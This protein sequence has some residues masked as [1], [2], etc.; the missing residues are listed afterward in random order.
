MSK[1]K[2]SLICPTCQRPERFAAM[3]ATIRNTCDD[4]QTGDLELMVGLDT[5]DPRYH[6]YSVPGFAKLS[7]NPSGADI[8]LS[9]WTNQLVAKSTGEIICLI[10]DDMLIRT[11]G[12]TDQVRAAM[13]ND[14][15]G[16][17][18]PMDLYN[19]KCTFPMF[20]VNMV[21]AQDGICVPVELQRWFLDEWYSMAGQGI[22]RITRLDGVVFEHM[23][24]FAEKSASDA[25]YMKAVD[26]GAPEADR[27]VFYGQDLSDRRFR[28]ITRI[29]RQTHKRDGAASEGVDAFL[30]YDPDVFNEAF[31]EYA[32]KN[33]RSD[34][35]YAIQGEICRNVVLRY[36]AIASERKARQ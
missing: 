23:H 29:L 2:L 25:T 36:F 26:T 6:D 18:Y 10:A 17:L 32:K 24:P 22:A 15:F 19:N 12:W 5:H 16:V 7:I 9:E 30:A 14:G 27:D 28:I 8:T 21:A 31:K 4:W 13:W 34:I 1:A 20:H 33:I 11:D 35:T 3:V